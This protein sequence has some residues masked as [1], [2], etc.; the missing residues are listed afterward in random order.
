[1]SEKLLVMSQACSQRVNLVRL[2]GKDLENIDNIFRALHDVWSSMLELACGMYLVTSIS[3][4][5]LY[6]AIFIPLGKLPEF[7]ALTRCLIPN[8]SFCFSRHYL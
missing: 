5:S 4:G 6:M 3:P 7:A 8:S 1:M 2:F